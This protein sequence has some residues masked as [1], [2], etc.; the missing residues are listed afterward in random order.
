MKDKLVTALLENASV[1]VIAISSKEL[2]EKARQTHN[3]SPTATVALGRAL[4]ATSMMG[5]MLKNDKDKVSMIID[6]GGP[7][8]RILCTSQSNA[9]VKGFA[10]NPVADVELNAKGQFDVGTLVG[11]N[12]FLRIIRD[13]GLKEPYTGMCNLRTGEIADDLAQYYLTSEQQPSL[14][15]LGVQIDKDGSVLTSGGIMIMPMPGCPNS[16]IDKLEARVMFT[17][18]ISKQLEVYEIEDFVKALF[19]DMDV[20]I[21][22][23][24]EPKYDCECSKER[25]EQVLITLGVEEIQRMIDEDKGT[26]ITCHFLSLIHI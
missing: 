17:T 13:M 23:H 15:S 10:T 8:G 16:V 20:Q 24:Y 14:V 6:G 25:I 5:A 21:V 9:S 11:T 26:S 3:L 2:T 12:G 22:S 4:S 7:S 19:R 18:D 1:R